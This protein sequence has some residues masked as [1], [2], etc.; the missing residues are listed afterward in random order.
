[1]RVLQRRLYRAAKA[2]SRRTFGVLY[3]KVSRRDVLEEAWQR[4]KAA[5]G[6]PGAD[7]Q[8]VE[9]I[10]AAG[11]GEF[12]DHV[13]AEL[14]AKEYRP[15]VVLRRHIPKPGKPGQTRPLGIPTVPAYCR[16]AQHRF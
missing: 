10:E 8:S 4:V 16:V 2:D 1:M 13:E 15:E 11:V 7:G 5:G 12:L 9:A 3:D 6:G 14:R